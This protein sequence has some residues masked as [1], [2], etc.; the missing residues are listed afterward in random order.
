MKR[1]VM[2]MTGIVLACGITFGQD[3]TN[4]NADKL[5]CYGPFIGTW[6]YEGP[7]LEDIPGLGEK[8]ADCVIQFSWRRILNKGA[9][10]STAS[11]EIKGKGVI[12]AEKVLIG[13]NADEEKISYGGATADGTLFLGSTIPDETTKTLSPSSRG[14]TSNG[15]QT[16]YRGVITVTDRNTLTFKALERTG[17]VVEGSSP[18]YTL[19]RVR[20]A[21]GDAVA[22]CPWKCETGHWKL[23][24]ATG[25]ESEVEWKA[26]GGNSFIGIWQDKLGKATELAGWRPDRGV[27]VATG[28]GDNGA[29]WEVKFTTVTETMI[30]GPMVER[31]S[32]GSFRRGT[33]QVTKKS[34]DEMPTLFVGTIDGK[35]VSVEGCFTRVK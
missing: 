33:F 5:K 31:A 30:K 26:S 19:K 24:D 28:Y 12:Y 7:M 8:G 22:E 10:E 11:V 3:T 25:Y 6:R 16:T 32:D 23:T 9:V 15:G 2:S 29:Y 17:S 4:P 34:E 27:F 1:I 18:V 35:K 14:T 20:L 21:K 13:W